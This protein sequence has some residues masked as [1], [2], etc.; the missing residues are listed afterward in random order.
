MKVRWFGW[1]KLQNFWHTNS[2]HC[3]CHNKCV[4]KLII[5]SN[6][7]KFSL[8]KEAI[9][10]VIC[11]LWVEVFLSFTQMVVSVV[12][13]ILIPLRTTAKFSKWM[14]F[15]WS[16]W[17]PFGFAKWIKTSTYC[18]WYCAFKLCGESCWLEKII[19]ADINSHSHT[20]SYLFCP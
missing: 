19:L 3:F 17:N 16:A 14:R 20:H 7:L 13:F 5:C 1:V 9:I 8:N 10:L 15:D 6:T 18:T 11:E 2:T 12:D 4:I